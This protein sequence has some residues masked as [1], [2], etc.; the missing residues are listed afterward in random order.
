MRRGC[1]REEQY[2][3]RYDVL[4]ESPQQLPFGLA[5]SSSGGGVAASDANHCPPYHYATHYT[6]AAVVLHYLLRL[7]VRCGCWLMIEGNSV[8]QSPDI[9]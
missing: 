7:Q 6:T 1:C 2:W 4:A 9:D 5:L 3:D 8:V